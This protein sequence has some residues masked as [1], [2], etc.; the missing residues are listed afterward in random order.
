MRDNPNT[1]ALTTDAVGKLASEA[2]YSHRR[3]SI[4]QDAEHGTSQ[5][6]DGSPWPLAAVSMLWQTDLRFDRPPSQPVPDEDV[7]LSRIS[8]LAMNR[9]KRARV[10]VTESR[11]SGVLD[12]GLFHLAARNRMDGHQTSVRQIDGPA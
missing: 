9:S 8:A 12:T 7:E 6:P 4:D 11:L 1:N 3:A 5:M 2:S 10:E